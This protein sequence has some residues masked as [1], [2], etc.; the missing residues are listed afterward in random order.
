MG[1]MRGIISRMTTSTPKSAVKRGKFA[2]D[3]PAA[4]NDDFFGNFLFS[5]IEVE[6]WILS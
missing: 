6:S 2:A 5:S 4:D 3:H 1:S